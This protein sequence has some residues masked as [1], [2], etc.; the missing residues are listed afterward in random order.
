[1]KPAADYLPPVEAYRWFVRW[2]TQ[3]A[4][5]TAAT[6]DQAVAIVLGTL[7]MRR[8][9]STSLPDERG[10]FFDTNRVTARRAS[11]HDLDVFGANGVPA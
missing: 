7:H 2:G 6:S 10:G 11:Q 5:V 9:G 4:I 3:A 8:H 1:V